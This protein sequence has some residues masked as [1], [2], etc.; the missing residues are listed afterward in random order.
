ML[1]ETS[2]IGQADTEIVDHANLSVYVMT[3]EYGAASQLEKIDMLEYADL[4]A[5]NKADKQGAD[6]ACVRCESN[7]DATAPIRGRRRPV[8][9]LSDDRLGFQRP[10]D[11]PVLRGHGGQNRQRF[12]PGLR[13]D[14]ADRGSR[15]PAASSVKQHVV[16][17][18]R[19]RYL[20]EIVEEIRRYDSWAEEQARIAEE[21]YRLEE[22]ADQPDIGE[23]AGGLRNWTRPIWTFSKTGNSGWT[24]YGRREFVFSVRGREITVPI[25]YE[26]LSHLK[27]PKVAVPTAR[28]WGDRLA[29]S[30]QENLPG[31]FPFHCRDLSVQTHGGGSD[32]DV[33]RRRPGGADQS[34]V[35][36][37]GCRAPRP[38]AFRPPSTR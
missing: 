28:G 1:L 21:A 37:P 5:I 27:L 15:L 8:A 34:P 12:G 9:G 13:V 32:Q 36:L 26:S 10:R 33:C 14:P 31:G 30:L 23:V 18:E 38:N 4:I 16:P 2:G 25:E 11:Q 17:P 24:A 20:A 7:T 19:S 3:P 22:A 29:W 35:P 6:D